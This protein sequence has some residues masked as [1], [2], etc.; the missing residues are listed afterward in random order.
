M[1]QPFPFIVSVGRSGTTL[2]RAMLERHPDLAIPPESYFPV[3]LAPHHAPST[4]LALAALLD[5]LEGNPRYRGWELDP[6]AVRTKLTGARD[7]SDA[8]RRL[9]ATYADSR[10]KRR[11][12]DKTPAFLLR[13]GLID[14]LFPESVF[15]HLVRDG[16]DVAA[17]LLEMPF[18]PSRL[19]QAAVVWHRWNSRGSI[20][21]AQLGPDRYMVLRYED[22]VAQP[23][24]ALERVCGF[25]D[26]DLRDDMLDH[27]GYDTH[28]PMRESVHH[29]SLDRPLTPNIRNWRTTLGA[30]DA[31]LFDAIAGESLDRFGYE[32][33]TAEVGPAVRARAV[34]EWTAF[35]A[36]RNMKRTVRDVKA[37]V[38]GKRASGT[39][40]D[41]G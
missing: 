26:L 10:G 27:R 21:G 30:R 33:A 18:G 39:K 31:A 15:I 17:S 16:R 34:W 23:R 4:P 19:G 8:M 38:R 5:E 37:G 20:S 41:G 25:I 40:D 13:M 28:L 24:A 11:Y 12:A 6:A 2:L 9:Y 29:A 35:E 3:S 7:Y 22:L 1:P 32:R 36:T 14:R